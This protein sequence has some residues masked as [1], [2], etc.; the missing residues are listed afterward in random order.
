MNVQFAVAGALALVGAAI[1]GVG[2]EAL[3][4]RKLHSEALAPTPFGGP[5]MTML[6]IRVTWHITTL[7]FVV[8]GSALAVCAPAGRSRACAGAGRVG[9]F[10]YASFAALAI[11]LSAAQGPRGLARAMRRHPGPL[12]FVLV[13]ALAWWGSA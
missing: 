2:G 9:A 8:I 6:M 13:A 12:V 5:R 11:G 3:V 7:A 1:H 10:S 4:V